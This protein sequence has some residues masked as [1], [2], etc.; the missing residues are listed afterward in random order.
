MTIVM[1]TIFLL[2]PNFVAAE[3]LVDFEKVID[4][5]KPTLQKH[6]KN[7]K[8]LSQL[9]P[10]NIKN[11]QNVKDTTNGQILK[12]DLNINGFSLNPQ[13]LFKE[14]QGKY[15][16]KIL[17]S[18]LKGTRITTALEETWGFDGTPNQGTRVN[19]KTSFHSSGFFSLIN[20]VPDEAIIFAL[21]YGFFNIVENTKNP[22]KIIEEKKNQSNKKGHR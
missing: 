9:F 5:D 8:T 13:V 12:M 2:P 3:R 11:I 15:I 6:F 21:D 18:D 4:L 1:F 16:F 19:V 22:G 20:L 10:E 7:F 14:S 17:D